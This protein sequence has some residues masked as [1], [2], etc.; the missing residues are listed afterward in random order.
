MVCYILTQ[1]HRQSNDALIRK[2]RVFFSVNFVVVR[3]GVGY[4]KVLHFG[5]LHP[6]SE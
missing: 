3:L 1:N 5:M 4:S 2:A 6:Y